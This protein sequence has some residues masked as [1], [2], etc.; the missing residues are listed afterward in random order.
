[1]MTGMKKLLL[2]LPALLSLPATQAHAHCPLCTIGAGA[3]AAGAV[4][5]G[6]SET[7]VGI[8]I[9]AAALAMG[10]WISR[11]VKKR[12]FPHQKLAISAFSFLSI[13]V[14]VMPLMKSYTSA[15]ISLA[16]E[17]GSIL[18]RT[19]L[20]SYFLIGSIIGAAVLLASPLISSRISKMRGKTL[21]YQGIA[22]TF[23]L[24]AAAAAVTKVLGW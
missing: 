23:L 6:V 9:G 5:L 4:W 2:A 21:P 17:Y 16:G 18:N 14:P 8:F 3:A 19:Y 13:V 22:I 24:L 1:M 15:Y 10:L 7:V 20:I 11:I 12:Y